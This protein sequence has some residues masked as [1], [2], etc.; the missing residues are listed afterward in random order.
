[1]HPKS[2]PSNGAMQRIG[3]WIG[4]VCLADEDIE[5]GYCIGWSNGDFEICLDRGQFISRI[6]ELCVQL[7]KEED[8]RLAI[9]DQGRSPK[10]HQLTPISNLQSIARRQHAQ[11]LVSSLDQIHNK[12]KAE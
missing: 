6:N 7:H 4:S 5:V 10:A 3:K 11:L 8:P 12:G 9:A 2:T 1:M